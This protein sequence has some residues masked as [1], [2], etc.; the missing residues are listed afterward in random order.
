MTGPREPSPPSRPED[1]T[2]PYGPGDSIGPTPPRPP[3]HGPPPGRGAQ[4][5]PWYGW[6]G[7]GPPGRLPPVGAPQMS[8]GR[9]PFAIIALVLAVAVL[10]AAGA[11]YLL[12]RPSGDTGPGGSAAPTRVTATASPTPA[13]RP[14]AT[15]PSTG[16]ASPPPSEPS[17]PAG[18]AEPGASIDPSVVAQ[19]NEVVA[20]VPGI[21]GLQPRKDVPYRF[22]TQEQFG[23]FFT[24]Q[25][26][27]DNPPAQLA[28]EESFDKRVGLLPADANLRDLALKLYSSAVAAF[29]D[30][31]TGRFTVIQRDS[32]FR[33]S[34]R[35]YVAHEYDHALQDQYWHLDAT[36][37]SDPSQ[38]DAAAAN[39]ALV[40]GDATALMYQWALANLTPDELAQV[41]AGSGSSAS[42][43]VLDS[44]PLLLKKGL[45]FP[46]T[47]GLQFVSTLQAS[48]VGGW[49]EVNMAWDHRPATTEQILHPGKY[50]G[51]EAPTPVQLPDVA[52]MLGSG[53]KANY[54]Q[55]LGELETGIW[56]ADGQGGASIGLGLPAPLPNAE[57]AAGWGGD[58]LTSLDGP[59]GAWAIVWQSAWDTAGDADEFATI[60][61]SVMAD[62]P[63]AHEVVRTSIAGALNAP[64]LVL[65]AGDQE[66]LETVKHALPSG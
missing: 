57:A 3:G 33:A 15:P 8:G 23:A 16:P 44:M 37:I 43:Q 46:Y 66:T 13:P 21:R 14:P 48:G 55:T 60:A 58:R 4:P 11:W 56:L 53:W 36:D 35:I 12:L 41:A 2:R 32:T 64:V 45:T 17:E 50:L 51:G 18:S 52:A 63:G 7:Q 62:L 27:K 26:D 19:I 42:Q 47:D 54:T 49:P 39:L 29:Y 28:A 59:N 5:P 30:P 20:Q 38:G 24:Q 6:Q 1:A 9:G 10:A 22:I 31:A 65:V 61:D 25:F 40:E 34:D